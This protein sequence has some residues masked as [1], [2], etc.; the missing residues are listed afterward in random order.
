MESFGATPP[1]KNEEGDDV[2]NFRKGAKRRIEIAMGQK[3]NFNGKPFEGYWVNHNPAEGERSGSFGQTEETQ[4]GG[5]ETTSTP[6]IKSGKL[7]FIPF[8]DPRLEDIVAQHIKEAKEK[9][10]K[11]N[12]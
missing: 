5:R 2:E 8:G 10:G 7:E 4:Y 3:D 6:D 12:Q 1:P 11:E 9:E